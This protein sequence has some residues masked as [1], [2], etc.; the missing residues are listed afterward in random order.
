MAE[1]PEPAWLNL[2]E[3]VSTVQRLTDADPEAV[4]ERLAGAFYDKGLPQ[5]RGRCKSYKGHDM[6]TEMG[7]EAWERAEI[8]WQA[9]QF[10]TP[11]SDG[12]S[13][14]D[15][16]HLFT[17]VE[18]ERRSIM[19]WLGVEPETTQEPNGDDFNFGDD[20]I[21]PDDGQIDEVAG[22]DV[23]RSA[24]EKIYLERM[25]SVETDTGRLPTFESDMIWADQ[26]N[27]SRVRLRELRGKLRPDEAKSGG[28][29]KKKPVK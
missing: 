25:V 11:Y 12:P 9:S 27:V 8:D 22:R 24:L 17:D 15:K 14:R 26:E 29:P 20:E 13:Q 23:S 28:A 2:S 21:D 16:F 10:K 18:V 3:T 7:R 1:L 4:E 19:R 6:Q 5:T